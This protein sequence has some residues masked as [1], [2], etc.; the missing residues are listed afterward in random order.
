MSDS[1]ELDLYR[2]QVFVAAL[3]LGDFRKATFRRVRSHDSVLPASPPPGTFTRYLINDWALGTVAFQHPEFLLF[4]KSCKNSS[5]HRFKNHAAR[6][7]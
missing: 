5:I 3:A 2:H 1:N 7:L 6:S 4:Q